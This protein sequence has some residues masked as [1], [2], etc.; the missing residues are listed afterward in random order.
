MSHVVILSGLQN[1]ELGSVRHLQTWKLGLREGSGTVRVV[2][3]ELVDSYGKRR[4]GPRI[5]SQATP[6]CT[7]EA[8][9]AGLE[10]EAELRGLGEQWPSTSPSLVTPPPGRPSLARST[11]GKEEEPAVTQ[12]SRCGLLTV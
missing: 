6:G 5:E 4:G 8:P 12:E 1:P 3:A 2:P 9:S 10:L 7:L 11:L